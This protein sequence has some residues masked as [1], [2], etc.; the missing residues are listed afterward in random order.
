MD[1]K[2]LNGIEQES[3]NSYQSDV[4]KWVQQESGRKEF[5]FEF[6]DYNKF[7]YQVKIRTP[8]FNENFLGETKPSQDQGMLTIPT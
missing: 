7:E 4:Q 8:S 5:T 2:S 1:L 6:A 3:K